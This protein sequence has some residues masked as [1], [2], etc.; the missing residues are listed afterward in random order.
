MS[1]EYD[2]D[3]RFI[4]QYTINPDLLELY[5]QIQQDKHTFQ[6]LLIS[7]RE[8]SI[9]YQ[10]KIDSL[11][12]YF[13][14]IENLPFNVYSQSVIQKLTEM[15]YDL[16]EYENNLELIQNL[17]EIVRELSMFLQRDMNYDIDNI[18]NGVNFSSY[19]SVRQLFDQKLYDLEILL[20]DIMAN[21]DLQSMVSSNND[22]VVS[23]LKDLYNYAYEY[24]EQFAKA[25]ERSRSLT[26]SRNLNFR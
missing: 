7:L 14:N 3:E 10:L 17:H 2:I 25:M 19:N 6:D 26:Y 21:E 1:Q 24:R 15:R 20:Q 4:T 9:Q 13:E 11:T 5:N 8:L 18:V 12:P 16:Q 23:I 22:E